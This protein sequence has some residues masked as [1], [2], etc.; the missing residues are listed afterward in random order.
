MESTRGWQQERSPD[1]LVQDSLWKLRAGDVKSAR[2][3][4]AEALKLDPADLAACR[5]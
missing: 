3:A 1:L 2:A 4:L 5:F